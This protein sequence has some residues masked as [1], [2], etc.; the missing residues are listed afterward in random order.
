MYTAPF[1]Q[2]QYRY[3]W[4]FTASTGDKYGPF[5]NHVYLQSVF[6][7]LGGVIHYEKILFKKK[8]NPLFLLGFN[9]NYT[10]N[11]YIPI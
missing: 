11:S 3:M 9:W 8:S 10:L 2:P 7:T 6:N 5:Y 4:T 1:T